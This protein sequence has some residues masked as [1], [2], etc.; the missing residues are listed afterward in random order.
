VD[1]VHLKDLFHWMQFMPWK[2]QYHRLTKEDPG[3][4][5]TMKDLLHRDEMS[6]P[7]TY[8]TGM[9]RWLQALMQDQLLPTK[10][11]QVDVCL[12]DS[13]PSPRSMCSV[14]RLN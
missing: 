10:A 1:T 11:I 7:D 9:I 14:H 5:D 8:L 12:F 6:T 4:L 13:V 2:K 3:A